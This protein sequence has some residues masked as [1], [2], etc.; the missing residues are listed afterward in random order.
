MCLPDGCEAREAGLPI[1]CGEQEALWAACIMG[2][3]AIWAATSW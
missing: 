2:N 1:L 3:T